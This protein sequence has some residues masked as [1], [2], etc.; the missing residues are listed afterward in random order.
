MEFKCVLN[1]HVFG[2]CSSI[3]EFRN[4]VEMGHYTLT[5]RSNIGKNRNAVEK[6]KNQNYAYQIHIF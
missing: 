3:S 6:H 1:L 2:I 4:E 5:A